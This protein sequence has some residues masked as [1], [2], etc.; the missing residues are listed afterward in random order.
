M[1]NVNIKMKNDSVKLKNS[2]LILIFKFFGN[3]FL[4]FGNYLG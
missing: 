3:C 1:Q 2:N 4:E